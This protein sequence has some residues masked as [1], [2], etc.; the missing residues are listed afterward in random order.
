[1]KYLGE[2]KILILSIFFLTI[3]HQA[4]GSGSKEREQR[5]YCESRLGDLKCKFN[6]LQN[7]FSSLEDEFD[8]LENK[9]EMV[10]DRNQLLEHDLA[11]C[12][13]ETTAIKK[14]LSDTQQILDQQRAVNLQHEERIKELE[15]IITLAMQ[16]QTV[17]QQQNMQLQTLNQ[18][19][20]EHI[21]ELEGD[22]I[23]LTQEIFRLGEQHTQD[24]EANIKLEQE[25][26]TLLAH[27][28]SE[29]SAQPKAID[30]PI[31]QDETLPMP[32]IS[33]N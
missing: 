7:E 22:V 21:K 31:E 13:E 16:E 17:Y 24:M 9:H 19:H 27:G 30:M 20:E 29:P 33:E 23:N 3:S 8:A 10:I 2:P 14:H 18:Q 15:N 26:N 4:L 28:K 11:A 25:R 1:M 32:P 6:S 5:E 12:A